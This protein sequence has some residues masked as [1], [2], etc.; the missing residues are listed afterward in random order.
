[1]LTCLGLCYHFVESLALL[2]KFVKNYVFTTSG[3]P[4]Q[5]FAKF[6]PELFGVFLWMKDA[7]FTTFSLLD[8]GDKI[9]FG[10]NTHTHT[11][12]HTHACTHTVQVGG[13]P[14][15][16]IAMLSKEMSLI[17]KQT[18]KQTNKYVGSEQLET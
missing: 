6:L 15:G 7:C 13:I 9:S 14:D 8:L 12:I 11:H 16:D 5:T 18:N 10:L 2:L 17:N 3:G 1:M 4:T